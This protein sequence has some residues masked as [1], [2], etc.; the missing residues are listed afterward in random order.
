MFH[1]TYSA[2]LYRDSFV[3][4]FFHPSTLFF[5][6]QNEDLRRNGSRM[7]NER[8]KTIVRLLHSATN[9]SPHYYGN[10]VKTAA[11]LLNHVLQ[12]ES[13]QAGFDLTA[14]RD[15]EFNEVEKKSLNIIQF[16]NLHQQVIKL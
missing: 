10:D 2:F 15:A 16:N 5:P 13:R 8:S 3:L 11:Q 4:F 1:H 7:D 14:M 6:L 9:N 12:Y